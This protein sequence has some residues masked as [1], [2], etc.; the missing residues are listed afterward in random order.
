[1]I[2]AIYDEVTTAVR[3]EAG[4]SEEFRVRV[5]LRQGS[6]L[7]PLLFIIVL[8]A[9]FRTGLPWSYCMRMT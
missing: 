1:M 8:K 5:G 4:E 9:L 6:L 2:Q 3:M 7:S